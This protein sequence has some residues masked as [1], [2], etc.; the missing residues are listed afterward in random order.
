MKSEP[1][2]EATGQFYHELCFL[3]VVLIAD[4]HDT[5]WPALFPAL[6]HN[7]KLVRSGLGSDVDRQFPFNPAEG[8]L[9]CIGNWRLGRS[10]KSSILPKGALAGDSTALGGKRK[11]PGRRN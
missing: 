3:D 8:L 2:D 5:G 11:T 10:E 7:P 9:N 1:I 4:T 6:E